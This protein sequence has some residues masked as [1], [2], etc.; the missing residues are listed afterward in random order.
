MLMR[1]LETY[2]IRRVLVVF[3]ATLLV[4]ISVSWIVQ[5]LSRINFLTTS[6]QSFLALLQFSLLFIPS[7]IPFVAPFALLIA[8]ALVLASMNRET[9]LVVIAACSAP[10]RTLWRPLIILGV[11]VSLISFTITNFFAPYA[12][13]AMR[14]QLAQNHSDVI[15]LLLQ[16]GNFRQ[17]SEGIYIEIGERHPDGT[18][19][20]LF[21]VDESQESMDLRY[22]AIEGMVAEN[23]SGNFLL[24]Q[25]GEI[26]RIDKKSGDI[27][28]IQ[29]DSYSF[30]L[31]S[32]APTARS[33]TVLPK[34]QFLLRLVNPDPED[35]YYQRRPLQYM[36]ELHRRLSVWL[37]PIVFVLVALCAIG[38]ARSQRERHFSGVFITL[39]VSLVLYWLEEV[40]FDWSENDP[41]FLPLLYL[42][43]L[44][45]LIVLVVMLASGHRLAFPEKWDKKFFL[46][47]ERMRAN[48]N[49]AGKQ[50]GQ[51]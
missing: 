11:L 12:R 51:A 32:F 29:F 44:G 34:D 23:N 31:S 3:A 14:A 20:K 21:I 16:E 13:L 41:A 6:G 39:A 5:L 10:R 47:V 35:G 4:T 25:K 38:D 9:E 2:I 15:N 27:S 50:K 46:I 49:A 1:L 37:F 19:G 22:Y 42:I 45:A 43:P 7:L 30:D 17:I 18:I 26:Q 33:M 24:L 48:K 40:V 28:I 36:A 8:V